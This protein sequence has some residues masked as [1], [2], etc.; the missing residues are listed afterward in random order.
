MKQRARIGK[1]IRLALLASLLVHQLVVLALDNYAPPVRPFRLQR[2]PQRIENLEVYEPPQRTLRI[3]EV[4]PPQRVVLTAPVPSDVEG[5]IEEFDLPITEY[6]PIEETNPWEPF[7]NP[8]DPTL[9]DTPDVEP[10]LAGALPRPDYP[11]SARDAGWEGGV[12]LGIYVSADGAV[13]RVRVLASSGRDDVD[14]AAVESAWTTSWEPAVRGGRHVDAEVALV[15][16]FRL[17]IAR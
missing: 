15:V 1:T 13:Q 7:V 2:E 17:D 9:V 12:R 6:T 8:D 3:P 4:R 16:D 5:V 14:R 10:Q 11:Q